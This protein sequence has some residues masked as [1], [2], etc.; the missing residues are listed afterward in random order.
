MAFDL[1]WL[2]EV[3]AGGAVQRWH[4]DPQLGPQ[5]VRAH[6]WGVAMLVLALTQGHASRNLILA[7]LTHDIGEHLTGDIPAPAKWQAPALRAALDALE[8]R[9][10]QRLGLVFR[11]DEE[12]EAILKLADAL[13]LALHCLECWARGVLAGQYVFKRIM[14]HINKNCMAHSLVISVYELASEIRGGNPYP[15][16]WER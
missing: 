13:E 1:D 14:H 8:Q 10:K 7:A 5:D 9:G 15:T 4:T 16:E 11:L 6:S 12:E 3:R 2:M